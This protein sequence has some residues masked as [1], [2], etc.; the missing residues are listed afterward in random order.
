MIKPFN[1]SRKMLFFPV[2]WANSVSTWI[3]NVSSPDDTIRISNTC[4]PREGKSL[5]L[6]V[7]LQRIY[8]GVKDFFKNH[9]ATK[10]ELR[11][12]LKKDI[13]QTTPVH[14]D[15]HDP[16][17]IIPA[18]NIAYD[19]DHNSEALDTEWNRSAATAGV[20]VNVFS[21][22]I[23]DNMGTVYWL[24]RPWTIDMQGRIVKIGAEVF[25]HDTMEGLQ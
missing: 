9:F 13:D 15:T 11:E 3:Q 19:A 24:Y 1:T 7:N 4:A 17:I 25:G 14:I 12:A 5:K 23:V 10:A 16:P 18:P 6:S 8:D 22:Q 21:R 2:R 20:T